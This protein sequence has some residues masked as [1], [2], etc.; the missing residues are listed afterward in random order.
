MNNYES[1]IDNVIANELA[2]EELI[3]RYL[4]AYEHSYDS[5]VAK[6]K[7]LG[8]RLVL[9][10]SERLLQLSA[11][12]EAGVTVMFSEQ[13]LPGGYQPGTIIEDSFLVPV[14]TIDRPHHLYRP[15]LCATIQDTHGV[16]DTL[17]FPVAMRSSGV[18]EVMGLR[19]D[20]NNRK[21]KK[22]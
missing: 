11:Y 4:D 19:R 9:D 6:L 8:A 14:S 2:R 1:P 21:I 20:D 15:H 18:Y 16:V 5:L 13:Q 22:A 17:L 10:D 7:E 3:E 12:F